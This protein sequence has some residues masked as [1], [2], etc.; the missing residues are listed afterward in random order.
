MHLLIFGFGYTGKTLARRLM[1]KGWSVSAT[2]RAA[3]DRDAAQAVGVT[4]VVDR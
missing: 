3:E 4:P 1:A 2:V